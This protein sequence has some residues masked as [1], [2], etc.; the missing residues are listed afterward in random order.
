MTRTFQGASD[1][2]GDDV[3]DETVFASADLDVWHSGGPARASVA[4]H[5]DDP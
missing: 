1:F 3:T 4:D 5:F 2:I